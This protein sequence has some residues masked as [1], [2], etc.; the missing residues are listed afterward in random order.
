ML[1]QDATPPD[2]MNY[3]VLGYTVFF[4]LTAIYLL[5]FILRSRNLKRDMDTLTQMKADTDLAAGKTAVMPAKAGTPLPTQPSPRKTA[6]QRPK[7]AG[8]R[9][10]AKRS[11]K[12]A[13]K[14]AAKKT[15]K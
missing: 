1:F 14:K 15:K 7:S 11:V 2:T 9:A 4:V 3:M 10:A 13:P 5:S 8:S 12:K 6:V